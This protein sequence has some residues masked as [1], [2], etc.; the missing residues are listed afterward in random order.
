MTEA[1]WRN[2]FTP[3]EKKLLAK[4]TTPW[5]IQTY[6]DGLK[7]NL[8]DTAYSP[9]EVMKNETAHCFEGAVFAAAALRYHGYP[10]WILDLE[11]WND[12]DHVITVF[13]AEGAWGA[14]A[15]SNYPNC[16]YRPPVYKNLRELSMSYFNDY[17]NDKRQRTLRKFS[18]PVT[19]KRFD[20]LEWATT[21]E[22]IW[23]IAEYLCDI[24]HTKLLTPEILKNLTHVDERTYVAGTFGRRLK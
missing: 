21:S 10:P 12:T 3:Q 11:A 1:A 18:K 16:R 9:R 2:S 17:F 15:L 24:P 22:P 20:Q 7:Y 8:E 19:L 23:F 4:L 5:K 13:Q 6:L 14:I